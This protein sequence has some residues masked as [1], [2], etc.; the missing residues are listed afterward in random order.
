MQRQGARPKIRLGNPPA[1]AYSYV[2]LVGPENQ[3]SL[4]RTALQ[5]LR[6]R[7]SEFYQ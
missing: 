7:K 4:A 6:E 1:E 5:Y 3:S 2:M